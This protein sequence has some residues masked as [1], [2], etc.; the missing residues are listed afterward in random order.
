MKDHLENKSCPKCRV[1]MTPDNAYIVKSGRTAGRFANY[2]KVCANRSAIEGRKTRNMI[3]LVWSMKS[4]RPCYDCGGMF[5]PEG[6]DFDHVSGTK[7]FSMNSAVSRSWDEV[8]L[9]IDKCQLVCAV[10]HRTRT[11]KRH[12]AKRDLTYGT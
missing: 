1:V 2:C 3:S 11:K 6:M 10:C 4:E 7:L 9:E 5:P 12:I 8:R